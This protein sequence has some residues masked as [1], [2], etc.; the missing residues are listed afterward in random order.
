G[1]GTRGAVYRIR[2]KSRTADDLTSAGPLDAILQAPQPLASWSRSQWWPKAR[3]LSREAFVDAALEGKRPAAERIRAIEVVTE[4]H[5]G[6][7]PKTVHLLSA[8][9]P[10]EVRARAIW[11]Y[12]RTHTQNLDAEILAT[13]FQDVDPM[14]ARA[15]L[16]TA[17]TLGPEADWPKLITPIASLLGSSDRY[18]RALAAAVVA[19]MPESL[20]PT[21]SQAATDHSARAVVSYAAGWLAHAG[22]DL[23]RVRQAM[24]PVT[25][26]LLE[27]DYPPDLKLDALRLVQWMLGDLGPSERHAAAFDGY[28]P[29]IDPAELERDWDHLRI[30]LAELYPTNSPLIDT[31]L[32]RVLAMLSPV[33][34][35]LLDRIL[36]PLTATSD[37]VEDIHQLLVA[38]RL[39]VPRTTD[40]RQRIAEALV[41]IDAK[42]TERKL[43]QD[44][45]WNDRFKDLY[46]ALASFDE[47]LAPVMVD[48]PGFG[49]PGHV[50]FMSEMPERRLNDAIE[51]FVKQ[52]SADA[53]YPW[54]NDVIF[55]LGASTNPGHR[56]LIRAQADRFAVRGA[57][58][59]TLAEQPQPEDRPLL[60]AGLESSQVEVVQ[61]CLSGLEALPSSMESAEQLALLKALRR[62]GADEREFAARERV[63]QLL[64]RNTGYETPYVFGKDGFR[65]QPEPIAAWT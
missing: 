17:Q 51:A 10:A 55:L 27:G 23:A 35:K 31:E 39:P 15:A 40:Q 59:M 63:V 29:G 62:L 33:N 26:A 6:L 34:Q 30:Q 42:F 24:S 1:R 19:R 48:V 37:P 64:Q 56:G 5:G 50:L 36:A 52:I 16:E 65:P 46:K 20:L 32:S 9:E 49:R 11:S 12:G 8:I 47:F 60:V 3:S 57:V 54:N 25:I 45:A 38:A 58:L 44:S 7:L 53:D 4:L 18:N 28:A 43:P 22:G 14:V 21:M 61:A 13:Y 41:R 2:A